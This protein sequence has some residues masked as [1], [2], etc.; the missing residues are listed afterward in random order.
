MLCL[1]Y[2]RGYALQKKKWLNLYIDMIRD[3]SFTNK[4]FES[5]VLPEDQKEL[6]L[7]FAESQAMNRTNFDD[8]ISRKGRGH[9]TLLSGPPG[10]GKVHSIQISFEF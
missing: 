2:M 8:F 6:I 3:I 1:P 10:V 7:S 4:A 9:I 5:L